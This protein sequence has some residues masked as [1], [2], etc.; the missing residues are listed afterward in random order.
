[1][2]LQIVILALLINGA[3]TDLKT[4]YVN[5]KIVLGI[6]LVSIPL[7]S[8]GDSTD[9]WFYRNI[10][11]ILFSV[12]FI[13]FYQKKLLG[14]AD[15]TVLIAL[16]LTFEFIPLLVFLAAITGVHIILSLILKRNSPYFLVIFCGYFITLTAPVP[17]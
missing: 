12:L 3:Y 4:Y 11:I 17:V 7:I 15:I 1:M 8:W 10:L 5:P 13:I 9:L 2:I 6:V 14:S 16:L